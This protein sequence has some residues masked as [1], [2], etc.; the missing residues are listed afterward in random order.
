MAEGYIP[1]ITNNSGVG[2]CKMPD[3]TLMQWGTVGQTFSAS[4]SVDRTTTF[5]TPFVSEPFI[6]IQCLIGTDIG[7]DEAYL[8]SRGA[9]EFVATLKN[10]YAGPNSVWIVWFAIGRWK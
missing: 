8:K 10:T 7:F 4:G 9:T 2:Y 5:A 1:M 3:G 6:C